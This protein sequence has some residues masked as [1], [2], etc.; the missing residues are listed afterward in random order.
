MDRE[1]PQVSDKYPRS[2]FSR[3]LWVLLAA[4]A[5]VLSVC[6]EY[7]VA[8]W[9]VLCGGMPLAAF[10]VLMRRYR[11]LFCWSLLAKLVA[12]VLG[13]GGALGMLEH[14]L[15]YGLLAVYGSPYSPWNLPLALGS[16]V[17]VLFLPAVVAL[18]WLA[19]RRN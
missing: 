12:S 5:L 1:E 11:E 2:V 8:L 7:R 19:P 17:M 10:C 9:L 16:W 3:M 4:A 18:I 14:G 6:G 15:S 13:F